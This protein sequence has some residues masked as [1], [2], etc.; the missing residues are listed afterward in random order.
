M[1]T[2][3]SHGCVRIQNRPDENGLNAY[4]LWTHL[5]YHTKVLILDDP[6]ARTRE[7]AAVSG[8]A[9]AT[10]AA[11]STQEALAL[12][13][14]ETPPELTPEDMELVITLGGDVVL[15][16]REKWQDSPQGLPAY[17]EQYGLGYPFANLTELF[18]D[19]DM[20]LVNLECVLKDDASNMTKNKQYIFRGA[21]N[22]AQRWWMPASSRST[23]PTIM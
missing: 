3:A 19:D 17:L 8:N 1:G 7:A 6:D 10:E 9:A 2:K 21:T 15:G 11:S 23:W 14:A 20:T 12:P 22:Y 18:E 16:T 13:Q 5:P 4:W